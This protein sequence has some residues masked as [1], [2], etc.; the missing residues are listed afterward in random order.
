MGKLDAV[1]RA[2]ALVEEDWCDVGVGCCLVIASRTRLGGPI[3]CRVCIRLPRHLSPQ[4]GRRCELRAPV[5]PNLCW[6]HPRRV[7]QLP[8]VARIVHRTLPSLDHHSF[9]LRG[10]LGTYRLGGNARDEGVT[11]KVPLYTERNK[12]P[13]SAAMALL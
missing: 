2:L 11:P 10:Q 6:L 7:R 4:L 8:H 9:D 5:S 12:T 3:H 1:G 13:R